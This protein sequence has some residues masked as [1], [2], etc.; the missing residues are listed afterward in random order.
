MHLLIL[1]SF[2]AKVAKVALVGSKRGTW[3]EKLAVNTANSGGS[4]SEAPLA[5]YVI[6]CESVVLL[7]CFVF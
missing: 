6:T 7:C 3:S 1:S 5:K 2:S 4:S